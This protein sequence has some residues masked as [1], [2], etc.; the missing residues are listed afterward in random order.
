MNITSRPPAASAKA[1]TLLEMII[2]MMIITIISGSAIYLMKNVT[3]T[4]SVKRAR[5]DFQT[6]QTALQTYKLNT[7]SYP[8]TAQ[9]LNAMVNKPT[10]SPRSWQKVMDAVP[11]DPWNN[12]YMYRF[13]GKKNPSEPEILSKG[14]DGQENTEDD[15]SSQDGE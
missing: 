4:A 15:L 11:M 1:Y 5:A 12:Q 14:P 7:L 9:G 13:P 3:N 6:I 2:V 8:T 10:P